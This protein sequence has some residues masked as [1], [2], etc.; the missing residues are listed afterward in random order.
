MTAPLDTGYGSPA[1]E[2][3]WGGDHWAEHCE[4]VATEW[5]VNYERYHDS[6]VCED[7]EEDAESFD[8]PMPESYGPL[9]VRHLAGNDD[10]IPF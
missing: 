9:Y 5:D 1:H 7:D 2:E 3:P 6:A 8:V 4:S 10:T